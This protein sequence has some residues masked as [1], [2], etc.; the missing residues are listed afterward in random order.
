VEVH[1]VLELVGHHLT[2]K[3][4]RRITNSKPFDNC[5]VKTVNCFANKSRTHDRVNCVKFISQTVIPDVLSFFKTKFRDNGHKVT[6]WKLHIC[7]G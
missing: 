5:W 4:D 3:S 6:D 1:R 7:D 2:S